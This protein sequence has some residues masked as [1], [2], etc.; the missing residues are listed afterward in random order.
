[1]NTKERIEDLTRRINYYNEQYYSKD[2]SEISDFDFDQLLQELQKLEKENPSLKKP[3]SPTQ[4]VGGD[5][6]KKFE[7]VEHEYPML[8]LGN[9]YSEQELIDFDVRVQKDLADL[10]YGYLCE[11]KFDGTAISL[12]YVNG[13]L[14]QGITRGNGTK[15]DLI[16][17][18]IKT[19]RSIPLQILGKDVP[20]KF[21]VRGEVY[22]TLKEFKRL[23][24][25]RLDIGEELF[26][27]PRNTASGTLKMQDSAIV[28]KRNLECNP[29]FLLGDHDL[30]SNQED[31][32]KK[33]ASW[34][35]KVSPTFKKCSNIK[36]TLEFIELWRKKRFELPMET[37]GIVI[38]VNEIKNQRILG[39]TAKS[40]RWAIAYKYASESLETTL[41][42]VTYQVGRTGAITPVANLKPVIIAGTVVKRASLHNENEIKRLDLRIG[43]RVMVEKGGEIIP[44]VTSIILKKRNPGLIPISY[45]IKCPICHTR[46][47]KE[48]GEA[49][50]YCPNWLSCPPQVK[51][52]IEHFVSKNAM[53][54]DSLGSE[55][56]EGL[57]DKGI[58]SYLS[59]LYDL[60][61]GTLLNLELNVSTENNGKVKRR[62][63]E[64]SVNNILAGI[65]ESKNQP[66]EKV[67]FALGIRFVGQTTAEVLAE[68]F[69]SLENLR[70][71][72]REEILEVYTVG[73]R[74]AESILKYFESNINQEII[75]KLQKAGLNFEIKRSASFSSGPLLNK[76]IVVSG[77]FENFSRDS[78]K[79]S[80]K[81]NGG[82]IVSSLSSSTDFL[83]AGKNMGPAKKEKANRLAIPILTEEEYQ[84]IIEKG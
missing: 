67:L 74:I 54:I 27:N 3:D 5:I 41:L 50:H 61:Q 48:E 60:K 82:K 32:L 2:V 6:T 28:A 69:G 46:L 40:P 34:G 1:M 71:S 17:N 39:A 30:V 21:E 80:V 13:I 49:N 24:A 26:S 15:G 20:D 7:T 62:L 84:N 14:T 44:K 70:N 4:R 58:I 55:T 75:E 22:F 9:T 72:S 52:R 79:Q 37:D 59:D 53:D 10:D 42:E 8:S 45:P 31:G 16:T 47:V 19:I 51:G 12:K 68:H 23:N 76:K 77:V 25:E 65:E 36:E 63:L 38:K 29:Y 18:N 43:D 11:L 83:L 81:E 35:F 33:L 73:E 78:I 66:F 56:I 57:I 64:K